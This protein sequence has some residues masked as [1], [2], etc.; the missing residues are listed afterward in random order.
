MPRRIAVAA[1][2]WAY[3]AALVAAAA[4]AWPA[5]A[6]AGLVPAPGLLCFD[7]H[8]LYRLGEAMTM[9]DGNRIL[10]GFWVRA[11]TYGTVARLAWM[12]PAHRLSGCTA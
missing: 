3:A 4:L 6:R 7:G 9:T 5:P 11:V 2:W 1:F 12:L 8:D 10:P